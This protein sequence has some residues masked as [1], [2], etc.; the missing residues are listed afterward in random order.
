MVVTLRDTT[1]AAWRCV[2]EDSL[3]QEHLPCRQAS[4]NLL[5]NLALLAPDQ[6]LPN[7]KPGPQVD[8]WS[9]GLWALHSLERHL[10]DKRKE[11]VQAEPSVEMVRTRLNFHISKLRPGVPLPTQS[12]AKNDM[13][14]TLED[15]LERGQRCTKRRPT[16]YGYK[17]CAECMGPWFDHPRTR[18]ANY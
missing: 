6:V 16:R 12:V 5:R 3:V 18:G 7:S 15:A 1:T 13:P 8:D 10:R 2:Y 11:I 17:G 4:T 9:C 14:A